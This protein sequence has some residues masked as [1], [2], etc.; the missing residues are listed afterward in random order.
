MLQ[1]PSASAAVAKERQTVRAVVNSV[2]AKCFI[3][4]LNASPCLLNSSFKMQI[5][6]SVFSTPH[7]KHR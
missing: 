5:V 2:N 7:H 3:V 4:E 6:F 1:Y